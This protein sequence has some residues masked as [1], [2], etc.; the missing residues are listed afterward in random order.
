MRAQ[1]SELKS[2]SEFDETKA[3]AKNWSE[4]SVPRRNRILKDVFLHLTVGGQ[5]PHETLTPSLRVPDMHADIILPLE[6]SGKKHGTSYTRSLET[7][8]E[9]L[10]RLIEANPDERTSTVNGERFIDDG[11]PIEGYEFRRVTNPPKS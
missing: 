1:L 10:N 4:L 11:E 3:V 5:A 2:A 7:P 6:V 8:T 9:W